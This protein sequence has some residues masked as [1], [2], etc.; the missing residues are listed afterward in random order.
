MFHE[1]LWTHG[2]EDILLRNSDVSKRLNQAPKL[3]NLNNFI[4][5][6]AIVHF[7]NKLVNSGNIL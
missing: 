2:C 5:Y 6:F 7:V 4:K 1:I 3:G